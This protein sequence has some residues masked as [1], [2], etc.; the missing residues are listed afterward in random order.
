VKLL[1]RYWFR[2]EPLASPQ[3][4]NLGCGVTAHDY[5]DALALLR[6]K[7]FKDEALPRILELKENVDIAMLDQ[8]HVL[9]NMEDPT[10]RGIWFPRGYKS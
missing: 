3:P 8:K 6:E 9:P 5:S 10:I 4:L 2:F 7:V 1:I